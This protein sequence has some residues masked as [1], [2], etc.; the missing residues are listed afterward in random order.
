MALRAAAIVSAQQFETPRSAA[1]PKTLA[2]RR[3]IFE[4][5][6]QTWIDEQNTRF[7][8]N[9]LWCDDLRVW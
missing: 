8:Q 3:K 5:T 7:E 6:Y 2:Q 1:R 4:Q 9:G